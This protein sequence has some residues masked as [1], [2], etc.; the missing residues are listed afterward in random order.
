MAVARKGLPL[1][2]SIALFSIAVTV[3]VALVLGFFSY[4]LSIVHV[5]EVGFFA[6]V[7]WALLRWQE[8]SMHTDPKGFVRRFM[9]GLTLKMLGCLIVMTVLAFLAPPG[10]AVP[11]ILCFALLYLAFLGFS[12]ARLMKRSKQ[13]HGPAATH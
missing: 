10:L 2:L 13:P 3:L 7:T 8:S 1:P 4:S 9:L 6:V 5:A 11:W 12:V